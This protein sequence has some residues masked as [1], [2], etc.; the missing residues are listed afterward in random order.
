VS[1]AWRSTPWLGPPFFSNLLAVSRRR[2]SHR[3]MRAARALGVLA[4]E[5]P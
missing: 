2:R 5:A 4:E 1:H 3:I